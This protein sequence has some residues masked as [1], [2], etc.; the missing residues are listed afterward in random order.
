MD[1]LEPL[2]LV[3]SNH[4]SMPGAVPLE[5][6]VEERLGHHVRFHASQR[7]DA[8][9]HTLRRREDIGA[10]HAQLQLHAEIIALPLELPQALGLLCIY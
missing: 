4:P 8:P 2:D 6:P 3:L 7:L 9:K 5:E 10:H 1:V